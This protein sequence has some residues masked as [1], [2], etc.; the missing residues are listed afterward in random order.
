MK[1]IPLAWDLA[2]LAIGLM[3]GRPFELTDKAI[4]LV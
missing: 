3:E 2:N 4:C 1:S